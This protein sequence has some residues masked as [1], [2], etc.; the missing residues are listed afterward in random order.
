MLHATWHPRN[1]VF[2]ESYPDIKVT[3]WSHTW[4]FKLFNAASL[5]PPY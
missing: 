5:M 4:I 1:S 3:A 2:V